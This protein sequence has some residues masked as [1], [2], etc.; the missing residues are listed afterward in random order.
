MPLK[1]RPDIRNILERKDPMASLS[2][3][4]VKSNIILIKNGKLKP[5]Y[6]IDF[7]KPKICKE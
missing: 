7:Y 1:K 4:N 5:K 6:T 3:I 2:L